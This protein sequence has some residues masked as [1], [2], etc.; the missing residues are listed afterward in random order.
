MFYEKNNRIS[1]DETFYAKFRLG[2]AICLGKYYFVVINMFYLH[3]KVFSIIKTIKWEVNIHYK[4]V[5]GYNSCYN[6]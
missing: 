4:K 5:N 2:S 3:V 6:R 1:I